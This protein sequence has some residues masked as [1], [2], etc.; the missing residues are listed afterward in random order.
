MQALF[1]EFLH[2]QHMAMMKNGAQAHRVSARKRTDANVKQATHTAIINGA[3]AHR[4]SARKRTD[5][6]TTH[7]INCNEEVRELCGFASE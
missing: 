1:G 5:A 4:V 2:T 6:N 7:T 3:Q